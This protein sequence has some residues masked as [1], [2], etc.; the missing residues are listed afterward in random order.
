MPPIEKDSDKYTEKYTIDEKLLR[1]ALKGYKLLDQFMTALR[2]VCVECSLLNYS[3]CRVCVPNSVPLFNTNDPT[4]DL[5]RPDPC[6][7]VLERE[8]KA[9]P[10][11]VDGVKYFYRKDPE[12]PYG[13]A[14][15]EFSKELSGYQELNYNNP[16]FKKVLDKLTG[17]N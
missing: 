2:E 15:F 16:V 8:T 5:E 17:Q 9:T 7:P 6:Q 12:S 14:I 11:T 13:Y 1:K 4:A 10:V 3:E